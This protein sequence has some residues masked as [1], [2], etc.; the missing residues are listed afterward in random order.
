MVLAGSDFVLRAWCHGDETSL[1]THADNPLI[2]NN[3][4]DV[5]PHPYTLEHARDWVTFN[6]NSKNQNGTNWVID[7]NRQC[8]GAIGI[9]LQTDVH[10]SNA[11]IGYWLGEAHWGRGI[12]SEAVGLMTNYAFT[13]FGQIHRLFAGVFAYNTASMRVLAKNGFVLEA[14]LKEACIKHGQLFDEC[15]YALRRPDWEKQTAREKK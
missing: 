15:L 3:V 10:R 14:T 6:V 1:A 8:V 9:V 12:V 11:E 5:F 2:F 13:H 4:R 7:V